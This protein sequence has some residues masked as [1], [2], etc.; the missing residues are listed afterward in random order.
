MI[1]LSNLHLKNFL[2][3]KETFLDISSYEGLILIEGLNID[4]H[5]SS[6][7]AGKS[8]IL[9]GIVYA[10]TGD[11]LRGLG[12]N[13]VIN[14]NYKKEGSSVSLDFF[15]GDTNYRIDRYRKSKDYGDSIILKREGED[16][17]KRVNKE[18]QKY[19]EDILGISYK[20]LSST[21]LL[22][23][24]L[25]SKFTQLSDPE[26]KSLIESTLNLNYDIN[27]IRAQANS[28][29]SN[30]RLEKSNE[31]GRLSALSQ[32]SSFDI[33]EIEK[34]SASCKL[35]VEK[36]RGEILELQELLP[37]LQEDRNSIN[38]K[39]G[40]LRD[41]LHRHDFL[42]KELERLDLEAAD[43]VR[44]LTELSSNSENSICPLCHQSL[45]SHESKENVLLNYKNKINELTNKM[46]PL[47]EQ[48]NSLP[49]K[50]LIESKYK[51]LQ[52]S[53]DEI[54]QK[55]QSVNNSIA[56]K[57]SNLSSLLANI[58]K[59]EE[60]VKTVA[61][62]KN[63][64]EA[65]EKKLSSLEKEIKKYFRYARNQIYKKLYTNTRIIQKEKLN[66]LPFNVKRLEERINTLYEDLKEYKYINEVFYEQSAKFEN[67]NYNMYLGSNI[68]L[69]ARY[70]IRDMF[71]S[72][73]K[74][75]IW[76]LY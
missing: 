61:T 67:E 9:E 23:E 51:T 73:I 46:I 43:Y 3:H 45:S 15:S 54:D 29:L 68:S 66:E 63:D 36:L 39:L 50:L 70:L 10:L 33:E 14:R 30:L 32:M 65:S 21:I 7:G 8:T 34:S 22:G 71:R 28:E 69:I 11:T 5:Y 52:D 76:L 37:K 20:V 40:V 49:D 25:S 62:L 6:N 64:I 44:K 35:E 42:S 26:K 56:A 12:V 48:L 55:L 18:T 58:S 1:Q 31:E 74:F 16:I 75:F 41:S 53:Y 27:S 4:G 60:M 47:K 19:L 24:G 17:S 13:D 2:S 57:S 38:L 72:Y 59:Y